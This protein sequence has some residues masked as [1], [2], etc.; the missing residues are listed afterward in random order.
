MSRAAETF[1]TNEREMSTGAET[2]EGICIRHKSAEMSMGVQTREGISSALEMSTIAETFDDFWTKGFPN[3]GFRWV[4]VRILCAPPSSEVMGRVLG[5]LV[6][7]WVLRGWVVRVL[8]WG[9]GCWVGCCV[10]LGWV[11]RLGGRVR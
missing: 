10:V 11:V 3:L 6:L 8:W 9:V 5:C 1:C 2:F 7:G 4:R